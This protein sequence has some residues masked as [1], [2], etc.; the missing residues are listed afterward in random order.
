MGYCSVSD[1]ERVMAAALTSATNPTT[2]TPRSLLEI[3]KV[4]DKNLITTENVEWYIARAEE[5]IN[6]SINELYVTP[7]CELADFESELFSS[8]DEYNSFIVIERACPLNPGDVIVLQDCN[9]SVTERH[10]I[11]DIVAEDTFSTVSPIQFAFEDGSRLIRVK[12]PEP[13][14]LTASRLAA[15]N[16]YDKYFSGQ[17]APNT[18][19]YGKYLR[20]YAK[21]HLD[22]VLNGRTILHGQHRIGRRFWNSNLDDRY[23]LPD[24]QGTERNINQLTQ[25]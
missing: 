12:F 14:R 13:I 4:F 25:T 20:D 18:S 23:A 16:I 6:S 22:N 11:D 8:V 2:S 24:L 5:E 7:L 9:C 10:E 19:N 21:Q 17:V 15:G 1:V 3:G